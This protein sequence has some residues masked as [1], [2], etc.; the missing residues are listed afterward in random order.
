MSNRF[1]MALLC[2]A[3]KTKVSIVAATA[4]AALVAATL[5][6]ATPGVTTL[7]QRA[8]ALLHSQVAF[9]KAVLLEAEGSPAKPGHPVK[10][11]DRIVTWHFVFDNQQ[12]GNKFKSVVITASHGLLGKPKGST[13]PFLQD[14]LIRPIPKMTLTQ[15]VHLL[16]TAGWARGFY[17]VTLRKPL[18]P[19]VKDTEYIFAMVGGKIVAVDTQTGKVKQI[20]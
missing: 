10:T 4:L 9:R 20:S 3:M 19:G 18:Y 12:T 2:R 13:S 7:A 14:Q 11:A 1:F 15:A 16:V 5:A 6:A 17:A 8:T